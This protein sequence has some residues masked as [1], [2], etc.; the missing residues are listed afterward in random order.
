MIALVL[1][2]ALS[3]DTL[4]ITQGQTALVR[5]DSITAKIENIS[6]FFDGEP[7]PVFDYGGKTYVAVA[8]AIDKNPGVYWLQVKIGAALVFEN[9]VRV[10]REN[11]PVDLSR[12]N[13]IYPPSRW[14]KAKRAKVDREKAPLKEALKNISP[15]KIWQTNFTYPLPKID[16]V[17]SEFGERRIWKNHSYS[18]G[19]IDLKADYGTPVRAISEGRVIWASNKILTAEGRLVALDRGQGFISMYLHLSRVLVKLKPGRLVKVR[20]GEIIGYVGATGNARGPHLHF[21]IKVGKAYV[22]PLEFIKTFQ[23]ELK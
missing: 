3:V 13:E 23:R 1:A 7:M 6:A 11:F 19:G 15:S 8:A 2:F 10:F 22:N 16:S 17:T 14:S 4:K 21:A 9:P 20:A 5:L 12:Q 18:H